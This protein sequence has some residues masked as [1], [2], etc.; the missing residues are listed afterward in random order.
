MQQW[1]CGLR[2]RQHVVTPLKMDEVV[3]LLIYLG[4][5]VSRVRVEEILPEVDDAWLVSAILLI[6]EDNV[7]A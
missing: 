4:R 5:C 7:M 6:M 3:L 2:S 1:R